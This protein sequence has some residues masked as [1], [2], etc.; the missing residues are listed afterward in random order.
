MRIELQTVFKSKLKI[1]VHG[2]EKN[3]LLAHACGTCRMGDNPKNSVVDK[4]GRAHDLENLFIADASIFP[5]SLG[6]N[7]ALTIAA[8]ALR[9]ANEMTKVIPTERAKTPRKIKEL[10]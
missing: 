8:N 4:N 9:M 1:K 7:P 3:T 5:T 6:V 2:G 10:A